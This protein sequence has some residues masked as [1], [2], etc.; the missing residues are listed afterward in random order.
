MGRGRTRRRRSPPPYCCPYASPYRTHPR[1]AA[2][3]C[4]KDSS[5]EES[6]AGVGG[7]KGLQGHAGHAGGAGG[8]QARKRP[9]DASGSD[10]DEAE[11]DEEEEG[12]EEEGGGEGGGGGGGADDDW[13]DEK[14][15]EMDELVAAAFKS[16]ASLTPS[17]FTRGF[18]FSLP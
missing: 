17:D 12:E 1:R 4:K 5:D 10:E 15:F 13:S 14:M 11:E 3:G 7:K 18:T 6:G 2:S 9:H 8:A 16:P